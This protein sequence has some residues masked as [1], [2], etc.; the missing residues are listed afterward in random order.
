MLFFIEKK[1]RTIISCTNNTKLILNYNIQNRERLVFNLHK[2][3]MLF[4]K[5]NNVCDSW[6]THTQNPATECSIY[7]WHNKKYITALG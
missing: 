1:N 3:N 4:I 6:I 7:N 2:N 5:E